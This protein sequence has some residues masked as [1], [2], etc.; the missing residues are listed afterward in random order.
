M[1]S[2]SHTHQIYL[3]LPSSQHQSYAIQA[4]YALLTAMKL[5]IVMTARSNCQL[6]WMAMAFTE[7][8]AMS[9]YVWKGVR[10]R[11]DRRCIRCIFIPVTRQWKTTYCLTWYAILHS[12]FCFYIVARLTYVRA[13]PYCC[14]L[15]WLLDNVGCSMQTENWSPQLINTVACVPRIPICHNDTRTDLDVDIMFISCSG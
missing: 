9:L 10:S 7:C 2:R 12:S 4:I 13:S 1:T 11:T 3:S 6:W 5:Q 8:W 14:G 15:Y